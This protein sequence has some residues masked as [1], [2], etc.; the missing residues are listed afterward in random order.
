MEDNY[1][2]IAKLYMVATGEIAHAYNGLCPDSMEGPYSR[3]PN[4]EVC[5]A[6]MEYDKMVY[7]KLKKIETYG[8]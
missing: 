5:V 1:R 4:C 2:L 6:L 3:D 8:G 7:D